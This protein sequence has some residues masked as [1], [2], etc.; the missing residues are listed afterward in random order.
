MFWSVEPS[1]LSAHAPARSATHRLLVLLAA[2]A[3]LLLGAWDLARTAARGVSSASAV[4]S[5]AS[6]TGPTTGRSGRPVSTERQAPLRALE[7]RA[8]A[9]A[10]VP[11]PVQAPDAA[12]PGAFP[13]GGPRA[14][15]F[16]TLPASRDA[17]PSTTA[18]FG[19]GRGP[20]ATAGTDVTLPPRP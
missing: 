10:G 4:A 3:V 5:G 14:T 17:P 9:L 18:G 15:S 13:A 6:A 2:V 12:P 20:P 1:R 11:A 16:V 7:V 8:V 19:S